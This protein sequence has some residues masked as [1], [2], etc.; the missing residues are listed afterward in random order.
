MLGVASQRV[1]MQF[2][3]IYFCVFFI[4]EEFQLQLIAV[5]SCERY[6]YDDG[7]VSH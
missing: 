4:H 3:I 6:A 5:F 1:L 2:Y 7:T